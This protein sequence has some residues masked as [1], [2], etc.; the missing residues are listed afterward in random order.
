ME[1]FVLPAAQYLLHGLTA[2]TTP[3]QPFATPASI[4][5][6]AAA[7]TALNKTTSGELVR[8]QLSLF[9]ASMSPT[10]AASNA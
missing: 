7:S 10:T 4:Y 5:S 1:V 8:A 6:L 3:L 9:L 2:M